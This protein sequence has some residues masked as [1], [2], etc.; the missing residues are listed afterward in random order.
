MS[1]LAQ[2]E[3]SELHE[4]DVVGDQ[5]GQ[6]TPHRRRRGPKRSRL[7]GGDDALTCDVCDE[8]FS[9]PTNLR[10]H[11]VSHTSDKSFR[12][13]FCRRD[14]S[15]NIALHYHWN[16][17]HPLKLQPCPYCDKRFINKSNLNQ[18]INTHQEPRFTCDQCGR[19]FHTRG[20]LRKHI[21]FRHSDAKNFQCPDCDL[22]FKVNWLLTRHRV[23]VHST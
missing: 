12:C 4:Q 18:H 11:K 20:D 13:R 19:Q 8:T 1:Y 17:E 5:V 3:A 15:T 22:S 14:F 21:V 7:S 16:E 6:T 9:T 2:L 10:A 23:R